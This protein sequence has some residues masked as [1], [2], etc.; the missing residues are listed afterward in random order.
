[1]FKRFFV[2]PINCQNV[3]YLSRLDIINTQLRNLCYT[4]D[5]YLGLY[6]CS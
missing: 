3:A 5:F 2:S 4:F 6:S 1:M